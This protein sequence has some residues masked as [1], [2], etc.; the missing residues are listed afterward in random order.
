MAPRVKQIIAADSSAVINSKCKLCQLKLIVLCVQMVVS[1][2]FREDGQ[3][4]EIFFASLS[5][6]FALLCLL[7]F[8][9][10]D[11]F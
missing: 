7:S 4:K 3:L 9:V 11:F 6:S 1:V 5:Y 10:N 8:D 2:L